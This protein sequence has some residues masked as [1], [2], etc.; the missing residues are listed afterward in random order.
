VGL[1]TIARI[2]AASEALAVA[3]TAEE[4]HYLEELYKPLEVQA[5]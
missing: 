4:M 5:I 1:N 2:E 3:L